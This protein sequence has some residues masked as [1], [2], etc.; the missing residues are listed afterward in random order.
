RDGVDRNY[1][2]VRIAKDGSRLR[3]ADDVVWQLV[4]EDGMLRGQAA[5]FPLPG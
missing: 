5:T 2:D 1:A 4:D 3:I